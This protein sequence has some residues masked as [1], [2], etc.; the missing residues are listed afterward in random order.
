MNSSLGASAF[1]VLCMFGV[2]GAIAGLFYIGAALAAYS[3]FLFGLY[4]FVILF[5][6]STLVV[7]V[8]TNS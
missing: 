4:T 8:I 6:L 5:V 2:F 7:H 3:S 1:F